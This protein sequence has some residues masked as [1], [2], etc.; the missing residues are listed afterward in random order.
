MR[1]NFPRRLVRE[2]P[3]HGSSSPSRAA[4]LAAL[5]GKP[6]ALQ[7]FLAG[8]IK[9]KYFQIFKD[10]ELATKLAIA[11]FSSVKVVLAHG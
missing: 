9:R 7:L 11:Y 6:R 2:A 4:T 3:L 5:E 1:L 10:E 8:A